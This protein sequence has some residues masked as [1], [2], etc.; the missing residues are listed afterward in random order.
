MRRPSRRT[1]LLG[2]LIAGCLAAVGYPVSQNTRLR[3]AWK[4]FKQRCRGLHHGID[5]PLFQ[6]PVAAVTIDGYPDY[7]PFDREGIPLRDFGAPRGVVYHPLIVAE[8][9]CGYA[10]LLRWRKDE[11]Y[12]RGLAKMCDWL[13][14]HQ[15]PDGSWR[16]NW[17]FRYG[18]VQLKPPWKSAITQSQ[19]AQ[20]LIEGAQLLDR[21][22]LLDSARRALLVCGRPLEDDGLRLSAGAGWFYEEYPSD[23][24]THVLNAHLRVLV[25]C[26]DYLQQRKDARIRDLLDRGVA[27]LKHVL[28]K[29]DTGYWTR[30]DLLPERGGQYVL[31]GMPGGRKPAGTLIVGAR[32]S[33]LVPSPVAAPQSVLPTE[34]NYFRI[35]LPRMKP[36]REFADPADV[37]LE[38]EGRPPAAWLAWKEDLSKFIPLEPA[39]DRGGAATVTVPGILI[40]LPA[41]NYHTG[42]VKH[43]RKLAER[44]GCEEFAAVASRWKRYADARSDRRAV[45]SRASFARTQ[46]R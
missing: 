24:P 35:D 45:L 10:Q 16:Y 5:V 38:F 19:A 17:G 31:L 14:S 29:Y 32:R 39:D 43:L 22:E 26:T 11:K 4:L 12:R 30:Y 34:W 1:L 46:S 13:V 42:H 7:G 27:G 23:P 41:G 2:A 18:P 36:S 44:L 21:P 37:R 15:Q 20:A 28:P 8:Y 33:R 25:A 6:P 9:G 3:S 40:G